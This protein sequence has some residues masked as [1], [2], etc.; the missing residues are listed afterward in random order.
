MRRR[1]ARKELR[2][3]KALPFMHGSASLVARDALA[4]LSADVAERYASGGD[5][6]I[7][8][9]AR[10]CAADGSAKVGEG[11]RRWASSL[12]LSLSLSTAVAAG[13]LISSL[14]PKPRKTGAGGIRSDVVRR[15]IA[16]LF[17]AAK[18]TKDGSGG[19]PI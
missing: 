11:G 3:R 10:R 7:A 8:T 15:S 13:L 6:A 17:V 4:S 14:V 18:A 9:L 2:V 19:D 5:R 12:S 1:S 16:D